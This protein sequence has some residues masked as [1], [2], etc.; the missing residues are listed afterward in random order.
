MPF[1]KGPVIEVAEL[2]EPGDSAVDVILGVTAASQLAADL[3][4]RVVANRQE[5]QARIYC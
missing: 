2:G 5:A 1:G 4:A 3:V